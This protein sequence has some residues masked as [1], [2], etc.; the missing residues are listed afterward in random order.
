MT[1][2]AS[3]AIVATPTHHVVVGLLLGLLLPL[4]GGGSLGS[5][6][7]SGGSGGGGTSS[8]GGTTTTD[9]GEHG[10]DVLALEGLGEERGPNGLDLDL[11]GLGEGGDLVALVPSARLGRLGPDSV[12]KHEARGGKVQERCLEKVRRGPTV[13]SMPSSA[14]MRAA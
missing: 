7:A 14:R 13:I 2:A 12:T 9:V 8:G 11:G 3:R 4:L 6:T 1:A 5:S 10:L